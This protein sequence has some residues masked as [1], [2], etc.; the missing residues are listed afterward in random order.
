MADVFDRLKAALED[1]YAIDREL[2]RGGMA[3]VYLAEDLKLHRNVAIKV[4]RP[5]LA[6]SLGADR[7]LQE[8]EVTA[9]LQHPNILQLHEADKADDFLYYIMPYVEGETLRDRLDRDGTLALEEALKIT[10]D[11]AAALDYAHEQGIVH[12]DIKPENVLLNRG[13]AIV[14]DFGIARAVSEAGGER[15]T[16]TGMAVGTPAYMSP[17]QGM[18]AEEVDA[19]SDVYAL[20]CVLFEMIAGKP[21]YDGTTPQAILAGHASAPVPD[22]NTSDQ[23]IPIYV[24][25]GVEKALA[26]MPEDRFQSASAF[27]E[28]LTSATVVAP[29]GR[30]RWFDR[31]VWGE[32][33]ALA[34][35]LRRRWVWVAFAVGFLL[36]MA[37]TNPFSRFFNGP[38][39]RTGDVATRDWIVIAEFDGTAAGMYGQM[40]RELVSTV[41][42]QSAIVRTVPRD[43]L[44]RGLV[45]AGKPDSARLDG[46]AARELAER[47]SIRTVLSGQIDRAGRSLSVLLRVVD[48]ESGTVV[49]AENGIAAN[50]DEL[51]PMIDGVARAIRS[52]LGERR[53][54]I[55]AN[56]PL[57]EVM[58]SSL[59]AYRTYVEAKEGFDAGVLGN[60][61][62][63]EVYREALTL[64]PDFA[65]AWREIGECYS[66]VGSVDS[67]ASAFAEAIQRS[68]RLTEANRLM[69]EAS[70]ALGNWDVPLALR[71]SDEVVRKYDRGHHELGFF[72][73][74]MGRSAEA[75]Q[76]YQR[77]R[78]PFGLPFVSSWN[79]IGQL[80][81]TAR[82]D[83]AR[84]EIVEVEGPRHDHHLMEF[85]LAR[86]DWARAD[87]VGVVLESD[88]ASPLRRWAMVGRASVRAV[89]GE[90]SAADELLAQSIAI[91]WPRMY[92]SFRMLLH[93]ASGYPASPLT[94]NAAAD[95]TTA[96][97]ILRATKAAG[98]GDTILAQTLLHQIDARIPAGEISSYGSTPNVVRAWIAATA[99]RWETVPDLLAPAASWNWPHGERAENRFG[100]LV[101][102]LLGEA[103]EQLGRPDSAA[104]Y[105][106]ALASPPKVIQ[107]TSRAIASGLAFSFAH[108]RL[109]KL[110]TELDQRDRAE[111]HWL[112]FLDNFTNPDPEYELMV[113]EARSEVERLGQGR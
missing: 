12:R 47:G 15:L 6:L 8:I 54:A 1:R 92:E 113:E 44:Q 38:A 26:K 112:T 3:V 4:L 16:Q 69:V 10:D 36:V 27:A 20:G 30:K 86:A 103:Y 68:N 29:V 87:S 40:A 21:P 17:E 66:N 52:E 25:R 14:A 89:R 18:G 102:W 79:L 7:F 45:L 42:D 13:R 62:A 100:A 19:R 99:G 106:E 70:M 75:I 67:A 107:V 96:G 76:M 23:G 63:I 60:G 37:L 5:E 43:Q 85:H 105:F 80:L 93:A 88:P 9:N 56:R 82:F 73:A 83:E 51:I 32:S 35:R 50:D 110:Y 94:V 58:T 64:D 34:G 28:A 2:G 74:L 31:G 22:L 109:A 39:V 111:E 98:T 57:I 33:T 108:Y 48:A 59:P 71:L 81:G 46:M 84:Q 24:K 104:A 61:E 90:V 77:D 72:L 101:Q 97:L 91:E 78:G 11:I 65:M 55:R 41:L 49:A 95:T 53:D